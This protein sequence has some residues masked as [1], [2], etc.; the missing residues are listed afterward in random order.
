MPAEYLC[1]FTS[2][3]LSAPARSRDKGQISRIKANWACARFFSAMKT[4]K[5][6]YHVPLA[7]QDTM[8]GFCFVFFG[9][10]AS[11]IMDGRRVLLLP[12]LLVTVSDAEDTRRQYQNLESFSTSVKAKWREVGTT[13]TIGPCLPIILCVLLPYT[14]LV[15]WKYWTAQVAKGVSSKTADVPANFKSDGWKHF[16]F[17][18]K[19]FERFENRTFQIFMCLF[20]KG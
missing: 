18:V 3:F 5:K 15:E 12:R 13:F 9:A 1:E 16:G 14:D 10:M 2:N 8:L 4:Q 17:P 7:H 6:R 19:R 20:A 11:L